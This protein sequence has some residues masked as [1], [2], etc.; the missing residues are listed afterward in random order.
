MKKQSA[1]I[2]FLAVML[3]ALLQ[4]AIADSQPIAG[5]PDKLTPARSLID[6]GQWAAAASEL[7]RVNDP[8][9]ADWNNLMGYVQRRQPTPDLGAAERYYN[10][11][12]R[13]DPKHR[14]ALEYSGELYLMKGDLAAAEQ[15][16]AALDKACFFG[17][18]QYTDLK[19]AIERYKA[20]GNRYV[21]PK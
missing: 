8:A 1:S 21:A 7:L 2:V 11:A 12:L 13:I 20:A 5:K 16:L 4:T 6:S 3:S 17:C 9:S 18:A 14:G 10:E 19:K 15:R